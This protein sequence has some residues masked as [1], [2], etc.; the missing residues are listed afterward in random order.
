MITLPPEVYSCSTRDLNI[1]EGSYAFKRKPNKLNLWSTSNTRK[2][3]LRYSNIDIKTKPFST[4]AICKTFDKDNP[5]IKIKERRRSI[6]SEKKTTNS[7]SCKEKIESVYS[8]SDVSDLDLDD[9]EESDSEIEEAEE[10][11]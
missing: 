1:D 2:Y 8:L 5:L 9:C 3:K 6:T 11:D 7:P 4:T 10:F